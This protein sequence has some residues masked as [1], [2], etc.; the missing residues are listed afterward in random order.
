MEDCSFRGRLYPFLLLDAP[1][2][3]ELR[4]HSAAPPWQ[5]LP[6]MLLLWLLSLIF[7]VSR[8]MIMKERLDLSKVC[9]DGTMSK[10]E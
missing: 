6:L 3:E 9:V 7:F 1:L 2:G 4:K 10:S 5:L 8:S